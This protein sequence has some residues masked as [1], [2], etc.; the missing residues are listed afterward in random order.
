MQAQALQAAQGFVSVNQRQT[1]V[2][3]N[4][5]LVNGEVNPGA[6][7]VRVFAFK[8]NAY[9]PPYSVKSFPLGLCS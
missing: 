8:T 1:Q 6:C 3:G 4:V 7:A 2:V 5:L 9:Q